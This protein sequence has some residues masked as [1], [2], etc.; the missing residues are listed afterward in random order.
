[1]AIYHFSAQVIGRSSGGNAIAAAA[2]RAGERIGEYDYSRKKG[3]DYSEIL[4]PENS[5]E[6]AKNREKLWRAVEDSEKRKDSQLF[7]EINVALPLELEVE[8]RKALL[9]NFCA[10]F[11]RLGMVADIAMHQQDSDNPHAHIMLTMRELTP[12]GFGGKRRDW[13]RKGLVEEWRAGW[14]KAANL[15]LEKAGHDARIDHRSLAVQGVERAPTL[16]Q[17]KAVTALERKGVKTQI[18]LFNAHLAGL[19]KATSEAERHKQELAD[20]EA[21]EKKTVKG[22]R[23]EDYADKEQSYRVW[24]K[25]AREANPL[26][27]EEAERAMAYRSNQYAFEAEIRSANVAVN[28]AQTALDSYEQEIAGK[29]F[30]AKITGKKQIED[31]RATLRQKL[32]AAEQKR[33][34]LY[35]QDKADKLKQA[36]AQK[37]REDRQR[38]WEGSPEAKAY[39]ERRKDRQS[40]IWA[41][42]R[43]ERE[44]AR[45]REPGLGR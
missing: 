6:W 12:E 39:E 5:P 4:T 21:V 45:S 22:L 35:T 25:K 34:E 1:M 32:E 7:R 11:T 15:A 30:L 9:K 43:A 42:E 18:G 41:L 14:A 44:K 23:A 17:G 24:S 3:V 8:E 10:Q 37:A 29:G 38:A 2:Y 16:H 19:A 28:S 27:W 33:R 13:N 40:Q 36:A 26:A 31:T 20:L